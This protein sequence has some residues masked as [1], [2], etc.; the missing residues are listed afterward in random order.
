MSQITEM[1][2]T[3]FEKIEHT[4]NIHVGANKPF[5]NCKNS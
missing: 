3:H 1:I 5:T 4:D 2:K